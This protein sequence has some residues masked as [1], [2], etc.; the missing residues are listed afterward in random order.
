M[1]VQGWQ[2]VAQ[3][4]ADLRTQGAHYD[5]CG[6]R[7]TVWLWPHCVDCSGLTSGVL[8]QLALNEGCTG[9]FQQAIESHHGGERLTLEQALWTPGAFGWQ[10]I[11]EGQGGEPGV[12]HGHVVIFVGDGVHTL[13]A[14]GHESGIGLFIATSLVYD[15]CGMMP[16]VLRLTSTTPPP[17][18]HPLPAPAPI[19][20]PSA[21]IKMPNTPRTPTGRDASARDVPEF[22]FVL[23]EDGAS[24]DNDMPVDPKNP[25]GSRRWWA[26]P[27]NVR[28]AGATLV[29]GGVMKSDDG[30]RLI[31][32]YAY[33]NGDSGTYSS[34]IHTH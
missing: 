17:V 22:N 1:T 14:R 12:D 4:S 6:S 29:A 13:E 32:R 3:A 23:L 15:Y 30:K 7:C 10:G 34:N 9:S 25:N 8:N 19:R 5:Q 16:G 27:P 31:A 26:P 11:N 2:V 20:K 33:P 18:A 24:V 28:P 21:M